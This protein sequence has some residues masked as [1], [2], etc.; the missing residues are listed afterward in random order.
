MILPRK[1]GAVARS[2]GGGGL[3]LALLLWTHP[4]HAA[5]L[6]VTVTNIRSAAG[7]IL[8]AVCDQATFLQPTCRYKGRAPAAIGSVT[9]RIAG[10]PPGIYAAQAYGDE[11]DNGKIDRNFLGIPTEGI[12]FSRDAAMRFGPPSFADA[13]FTLGPD[14]GRITF[15][16]RYYN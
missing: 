9:I 1:A 2:A 7:H 13:A 10:I 4:A 12:G 14:G 16:L 11:N 5:D 6:E 8:V 15:A 3:A